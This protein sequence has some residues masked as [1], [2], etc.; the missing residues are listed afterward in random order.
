MGSGVK[1]TGSDASLLI[2]C[3]QSRACGWFRLSRYHDLPDSLCLSLRLGFSHKAHARCQ[4]QSI[5]RAGSQVHTFRPLTS[6]K[7][8]A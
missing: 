7:L 4:R 1:P 2:A 3:L 5:I 8:A 6:I